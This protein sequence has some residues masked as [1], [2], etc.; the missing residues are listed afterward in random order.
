MTGCRRS[1]WFISSGFAVAFLLTGTATAQPTPP[2]PPPADPP[3]APSGVSQPGQPLAA[4][5]GLVP[6]AVSVPAPRRFNFHIKPGTPTKDL[7]PVA[8]KPASLTGP[9]L[10]DDL[11]Q[12]PEVEF[13]AKPEKVTTD[14]K[15]I[16]Q[17]AHQLAKI[18][19]MNAKKTDA[20][21]AALLENRSDLAG[22]PF[23]MGDDCRSHGDKVKYFT[24]AA[25]TVRQ[26]MGGNQVGFQDLG[27]L[28]VR[29]TAIITTPAPSPPPPL[30]APNTSSSSLPPSVAT[31]P[32]PVPSGTL[33]IQN[34]DI[35][36]E[37]QGGPP[38]PFWKQ[39]LALCE[40]QDATRKRA[41]KKT[42]ELV[43]LA[44]IAALTQMLAAESPEIRLGLVKYLTAVPHVEATRAI[45]RMAIFSAEDDVRAAAITALKV[46][47]EKDYTDI[48][49]GGLRYPWPAVAKR[50]ADAIVKL[51]RA[52][53]IPELLA[54]LEN[55]DPRIPMAKEV[56]GKSVMVVREVVKINHHRN[57]MM[58]HSPAASGSPNPNAIQAEVAVQG[59]PLPT[60][61]QG[62]QQSTP[63]L[64]IRMD[65]TYLRSDFSAALP[66]K[67]AHP[68]PE[69]QRFDFLVRER[70]MT[71]DEVTAYRDKL[72]PKEEGV[73]SPYHKAAVA[74]LREL[75]G[76]DTAPTAKAWRKLLKREE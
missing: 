35:I 21:M 10:T 41:D 38:Q 69:M 70:K 2:A 73:L 17:A 6:Q 50:S 11:S 71:A 32:Q 16:E 56:D 53:L 34:V 14:G 43:V 75:T 62:Y 63:E 28:G 22:L 74:A 40:Q 47:R 23:V 48:L 51:E 39:Y 58:C 59:Q 27:D 55:A 26:A 19:Y 29:R 15:L 49:V 54:L 37:I 13:Q 36:A 25:N 76:K 9:V 57:C 44:R 1:S 61:A 20:F 67:E 65:V 46:R 66:V 3:P 52:D 18:N 7:L 64:M 72:T 8:P 33:N 24:E 4:P 42:A 31:A 45:A 5:T 12:V 68:W 30:P 60:P